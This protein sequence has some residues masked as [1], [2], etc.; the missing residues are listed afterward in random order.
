MKLLCPA[1]STQFGLPLQM[2]QKE[3]PLANV[4]SPIGQISLQR[5]QL[6]QRASSTRSGA[7]LLSSGHESASTLIADVGHLSMHARHFM[8]ED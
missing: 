6:S 7:A 2:I 8:S 1:G 4:I 3:Q 5:P